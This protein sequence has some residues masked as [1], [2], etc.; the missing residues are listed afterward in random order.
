M[1]KCIR[2]VSFIV[3]TFFLIDYKS[4]SLKTLYRYKQRFENGEYMYR[5]INHIQLRGSI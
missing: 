5:K 1:I 2:F 3:V 4:R